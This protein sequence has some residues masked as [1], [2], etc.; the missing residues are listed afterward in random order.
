M[1]LRADLDTFCTLAPDTV[2]VKIVVLLLPLQYRTVYHF[3][4]TE[5]KEPVNTEIRRSL[6]NCG[7]YWSF[8]SPVSLPEFGSSS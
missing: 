7:S 5:Q 1:G 2:S 6:Q 4:F 8:M 3:T